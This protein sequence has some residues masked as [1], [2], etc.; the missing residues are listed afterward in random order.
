VELSKEEGY[1]KS[2]GDKGLG[3]FPSYYTFHFEENYVEKESKKSATALPAKYD[4]RTLGGVTSVKDQG[5]LGACWSFSTM[6]AIESNWLIK[7]YGS[8]DLSEQNMATCHGFTWGVDDGGNDYIA[9]A[10]LTRLKGPV[11]EASDPYS[12]NPDATCKSTGLVIP[13][14]TPTAE[15]LPKDINIVKKNI[16]KHGALSA[17][18]STA[19]LPWGDYYNTGNYTFNYNGTAPPDHAVLVVGWDDNRYVEGGTSSPTPSFGAWIVKNSWGTFFGDK[20]YFY[21]SYKD[22][23]FL[24]SVSCY[25]ERLE[26][27]EVDTMYYNDF[28]GAT[29]A[30][31]FRQ[32]T[33]Y[34][35]VKY[36]APAKHFI[37]QIGTFINATGS[38]IDIEVYKEFQGDTLLTNLIASSYGNLVKFPG[39]QTFDIAAVVEGDYYI[40][41]KYFTPGYNYPVPVEAEIVYQGEEFAIPVLE[42]SGRHWISRDSEKW[43]ALG[44]NIEDSEVDLCI[45][46]YVDRNTILNAFFTSDKTYTCVGSPVIFTDQSNGEPSEYLWDFGTGANLKT[47]T[48]KGPH[49]VTFNTPGIRNISLTIKDANQVE[50]KLTRKSYIEAAANELDIFLPYS[51][52]QL[53]NG[54]S[55][56]LTAYGADTY[57]WTPATGLDSTKGP[58]VIASPTSTITYTVQ[59]A[60][61]TCTGSA[62]IKIN[63]VQNPPN[64]DVCNAIKITPGGRIGP[65]TN[66]Y[67]TVEDGEPAPPE[68]ECNKPLEWC[69]EGGL[70]NSVWFWFEGPGT[71]M[72][73]FITE[74]FDTQIAVYK[75]DHCDSILNDGW[76]LVAANDD[77]YGEDK[78]F[79]AAID[80]VTLI[81]GQKYFLQVDGSAGGDEGEFHIIF[82]DYPISN[83]SLEIDPWNNGK[84]NVYPNPGNGIFTVSL[85]TEYTKNIYLRV[86]NL[87]GQ[88]VLSERFENH[89]KLFKA[90]ID[91]GNTR[92]GYYLVEL[93]NEEG[94]FRRPL[95]V[96]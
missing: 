37:R 10:Y 69:V 11:T 92:P 49:S 53:V 31:G 19:G 60:M 4:L 36:T 55:L 14:Y 40:K 24:T 89:S 50:R 26:V 35:L 81:P 27:N 32:E 8:V 38:L 87:Q 18:M 43:L 93:S 68:G 71:K 65:F 46:A 2:A 61:G 12:T 80:T 9:L 25:P 70:Q 30:Y 51:E 76:V 57:T 45:R 23:R 15:F 72:A 22:T 54:K 74:G 59:G 6:G 21:I 84:M 28:L 75:A 3:Y 47:A 95:V 63:V 42:D 7:G 33:A 41:V 58:N 86:Y 16:M 96:K 67:A 94:R 85:E 79:A 13:A 77:Y 91:L 73:S 64:D 82:W 34:G 78:F 39:Y 44:A 66:I 17:S 83:E 62:S 5:P 1:K 20:G 90:T 48:T 88:T 56:P 52:K 29:S